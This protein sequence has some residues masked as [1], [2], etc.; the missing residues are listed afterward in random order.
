MHFVNAHRRSQR[1]A[2]APLLQPGLI[3]PLKLSRAPHDRG[4]LRRLFKEKTERIRLQHYVSV[5]IFDLELVMRPFA[6]ARNKNLPDTRRPKRSHG[7]TAA[8]PLV[9]IANDTDAL[10]VGRPD[11]EAGAGDAID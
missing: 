1:I 10:R 6:H 8:I 11:G 3:A 4:V 5:K 7:M 9:E 2:L